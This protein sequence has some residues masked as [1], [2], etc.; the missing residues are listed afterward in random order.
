MDWTSGRWM[1]SWWRARVVAL[2]SARR[3]SAALQSMRNRAGSSRGSIRRI[4]T[5]SMQTLPSSARYRFLGGL[6]TVRSRHPRQPPAHHVVQLTALQGGAPANL[7]IGSSSCGSRR[8]TPPQEIG[9]QQAGLHRELATIAIPAAFLGP[10]GASIAWDDNP[11]TMT[12]SS[13]NARLSRPGAPTPEPAVPL[14]DV[15]ATSPGSPLGHHPIRT[16]NTQANRAACRT[17]ADRQAAGTGT[18]HELACM[19]RVRGWVTRRCP[20]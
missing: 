9:H 7:R 4:A 1:A 20:R 17:C 16:V 11:P 5:A 14:P 8:D 18:G 15:L 19:P 12:P 2:G 13:G 10:V 6:V 3:P